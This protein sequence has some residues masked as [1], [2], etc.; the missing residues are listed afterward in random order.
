MG[1]FAPVAPTGERLTPAT[2]GWFGLAMRAATG[3]HTPIDT[4]LR[5]PWHK[6]LFVWDEA[7]NIHEETWGLLLKVW[8]RRQNDE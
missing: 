5:W 3:S 4:V 1:F 7:S 2:A 8:Y 6:T